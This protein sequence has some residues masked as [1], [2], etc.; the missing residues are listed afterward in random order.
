MSVQPT[1]EEKA[2]VHYHLEFLYQQGV[3]PHLPPFCEPEGAL[4]DT[5]ALAD[6][7]G[8]VPIVRALSTYIGSAV[9]PSVSF[10]WGI[11]MRLEAAGQIE[12][13][14]SY[15][16]IRIPFASAGKPYL[17]GCILAHELAHAYL[18]GKHVRLND[19]RQSEILTDLAAVN[20]GLG[21]FMLNGVFD[22]HSDSENMRTHMGYLSPAAMTLAYRLVAERVNVES[23][24]LLTNL[25]GAARDAV[26]ALRTC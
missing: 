3:V 8:L 5:L 22:G 10:D 15:R 6:D 11:T 26:T 18:F 7:Q 19:E 4:Y 14:T 24:A 20:I 21:K 23:T 13:R 16:H 2:W 1:D 9:A 12:M 17:L 25:Q